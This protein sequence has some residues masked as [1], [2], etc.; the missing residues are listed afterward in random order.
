MKSIIPK[1]KCQSWMCIHVA[2]LI[3]Q[4]SMYP[5]RWLQLQ[6]QRV[7]LL[8]P[9]KV[10]GPAH[11]KLITPRT[12]N[13]SVGLPNKALFSH[14]PRARIFYCFPSIL[15]CFFLH[16]INFRCCRCC[17]CSMVLF[18]NDFTSRVKF[19]YA[20]EVARLITW[21]VCCPIARAEPRYN[22]SPYSLPLPHRFLPNQW[23]LTG[24]AWGC[25]HL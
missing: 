13:R 10:Y 14:A 1:S 25:L 19:P 22:C 6:L 2:Q 11:R 23:P 5:L 12:H 16:F 9:H 4:Y 8:W 17:S 7:L 18:W 21:E 3:L 15:I 20:K 24:A